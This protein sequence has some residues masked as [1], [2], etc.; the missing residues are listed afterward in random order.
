M[1]EKLTLSDFEKA[2]KALEAANVLG[3]KL[4]I[5]CDGLWYFEEGTGWLPLN[6]PEKPAGKFNDDLATRVAGTL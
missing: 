3:K 2:R 6:G 1:K 5:T 4:A